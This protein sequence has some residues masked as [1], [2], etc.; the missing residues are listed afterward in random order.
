MYFGCK[1]FNGKTGQFYGFVNQPNALG[2]ANSDLF[3]YKL[4]FDY[5]LKLYS[6]YDT[7]GNITN[8]ISFYQ[9]LNL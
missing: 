3:F 8:E 7:F 9:Y 5:D 6:V 4:T 2:V 1:F